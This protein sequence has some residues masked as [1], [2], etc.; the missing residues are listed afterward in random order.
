MEGAQLVDGVYLPAGETH[1]VEHMT[2]NRHLVDGR[3]SYQFKK[4]EAALKFVPPARRRVALDVGAHVGLWSMQLIKR[5]ERV[6]A[7]EPVPML[8]GLFGHNLAVNTAGIEHMN[9]MVELHHCALGNERG[10]VD[11]QIPVET[12]GNAHVAIAG[13][14]PGTRG[15]E[16]PERIDV[17]RGVEMKRLDDFDLKNVDFIKI[18]V[19][20]FERQVLLGGEKMIRRDLP[21]I[22]IEQK[23]NDVAYGDKPKA[24]LELLKKWGGEVKGELGGDYIVEFCRPC[25]KARALFDKAR[26]KL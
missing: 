23:G 13:A 15:V 11:M 5:F 4:L 1:L 10:T 9:P 19:E 14:H 2:K 12:T 16:H 3:G 26:G 20:G 22:V 8:R 21:W 25:S 24:A 7:F 17:V 18:D 6:H